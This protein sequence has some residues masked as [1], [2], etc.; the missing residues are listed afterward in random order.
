MRWRLAC[1]WLGAADGADQVF[2]RAVIGYGGTARGLHRNG[3]P[4]G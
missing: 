4:S 3:W 2:A 1:D